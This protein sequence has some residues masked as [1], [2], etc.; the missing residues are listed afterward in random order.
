M[1]RVRNI[2]TAIVLGGFMFLV[3][4]SIEAGTSMSYTCVLCRLGRIESTLFGVKTSTNHENECSR[5]YPQNVEPSHTH[6]WERGTCMTL[7]NALGQP[8]GV[9]CQPGQYPIRLLSS[10]T[11]M[12]VYSGSSPHPLR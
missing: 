6:I 4:G 2:I 3:L 9:G 10:S 1:F 11:Q 8:M 12:N 7:L 5:W